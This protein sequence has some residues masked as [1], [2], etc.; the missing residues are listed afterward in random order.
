MGCPGTPSIFLTADGGGRRT[1]N[2]GKKIMMSD[3]SKFT[4]RCA[5]CGIPCDWTGLC[6]SEECNSAADASLAASAGEGPEEELT[7]WE[8]HCRDEASECGEYAAMREEARREAAMEAA[9][10]E[11]ECREAAEEDARQYPGG[12]CEGDG[13]GCNVCSAYDPICF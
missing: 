1:P 6:G 7:G 9:M 13:W 11:D 12:R 10:Y 3:S 8:E 4:Y 5:F 2:E